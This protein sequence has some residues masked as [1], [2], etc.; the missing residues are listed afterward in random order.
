MPWKW[1]ESEL[2]RRWA[3]LAGVGLVASHQAGRELTDLALESNN[4]RGA[5]LARAKLC[6][7][8][9]RRAASGRDL[10]Q[11]RHARRRSGRREPVS[12]ERTKDLRDADARW[13]DF[14]GASLIEVDFRNASL[15]ARRCA[16]RRRR[17]DRRALRGASQLRHRRVRPY[18]RR[19]AR[20]GAQRRLAWP[21]H[22][23]PRRCACPKPSGG[24]T[25]PRW[26]IRR[27]SASPAAALGEAAR[28]AGADGARHRLCRGD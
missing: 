6:K 26:S 12:R 23:Q 5:E 16:R 13:A 21:N 4:L 27:P 9:L 14:E 15:Q 7:T 18:G 17:A 25:P 28:R 24:V 19:S 22:P 20:R 3:R 2:C 11:G 8:R 10:A 1:P